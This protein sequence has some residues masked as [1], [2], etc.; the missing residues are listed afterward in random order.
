MRFSSRLLVFVLV[1]G[2]IAP[3]SAYAA[4]PKPVEIVH[5]PRL[6]MTVSEAKAALLDSIKHSGYGPVAVKITHTKVAILWPNNEVRFL[7]SEMSNLSLGSPPGLPTIS[8]YHALLSNGLGK[9][10][11]FKGLLWEP[12]AERYA[13]MFIDAVVVLKEAALAP[14]PE[15]ETDF[16]DFTAKAETWLAGLPKPEMPDDARANKL[17][18]EDEFK[19]KDFSAALK[20]YCKALELFPMWPSGHYNAALLAAVAEDY[21]LAGHHMRR[22]LVL[23]PDAQDAAAAKDKLLLWQLKAKE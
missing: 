14:D 10:G 9:D 6:P 2:Y 23:A 13:I 8:K 3:E 4:K 20:A 12:K 21:E 11:A 18:A 15:E 7:F 17:L 1:L 16:A 5:A 19:R 22:Y